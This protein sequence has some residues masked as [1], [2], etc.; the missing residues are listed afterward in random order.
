MKSKIA[1]V[2]GGYVGAFLLTVAIVAIYAASTS[3][4]DPMASSGMYAFGDLLLFLAVF[5]I[6]AIPP[7]GAALF[8]L[9]ANRLF[10]RGLLAATLVIALTGLVAALLLFRSTD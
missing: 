4:P 1:W 5:A 8:F 3:G 9:R 10:W 2:A 6:A 7:T